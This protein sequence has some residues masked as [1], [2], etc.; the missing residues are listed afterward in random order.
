MYYHFNNIKK[1]I[2]IIA[3]FQFSLKKK[4]I[5]W[6]FQ[7]SLTKKKI[8]WAFKFSLKN[9]QLICR[10]KQFWCNEDDVHRRMGCWCRRFDII[11]ITL[12]GMNFWTRT[13]KSSNQNTGYNCIQS[14]DWLFLEYHYK[15]ITD[16]FDE[17]KAWL[18]IHQLFLNLLP[19]VSHLRIQN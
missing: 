3:V 8:K 18:G 7:F 12:L 1:K 5:K 10:V 6:V 9:S 2:I 15:N 11:V 16:K 19:V 17:H 4:L 13:Q 14:S